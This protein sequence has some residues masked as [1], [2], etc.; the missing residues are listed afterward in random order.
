MNNINNINLF[1]NPNIIYNNNDNQEKNLSEKNPNEET[2][3]KI[4]RKYFILLLIY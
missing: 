1:Q 4:V 3:L 2:A